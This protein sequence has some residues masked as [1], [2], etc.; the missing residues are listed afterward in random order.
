MRQ[1]DTT[2][3]SPTDKIRSW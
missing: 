2:F 3:P 1:W